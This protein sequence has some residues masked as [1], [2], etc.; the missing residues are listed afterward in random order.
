MK[1]EVSEIW[2]LQRLGGARVSKGYVAE[3]NNNCIKGARNVER[4]EAQFSRWAR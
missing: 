3:T 1:M 4:V 2:S